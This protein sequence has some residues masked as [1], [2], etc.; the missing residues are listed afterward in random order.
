MDEMCLGPPC[1]HF[2]EWIKTLE[3]ARGYLA[4]TALS[5]PT[6]IHYAS[7]RSKIKVAPKA[8]R[9]DADGQVFA[10]KGEMVRYHELLLLERA[11]KI[12]NIKR[13]P[14][15]ELTI[16]GPQGSLKP[17]VIRSERYPEGR[18]CWYTADFQYDEAVP[19]GWVTVV[20]DFKGYQTEVS[21]LRIAVAE[22]I[23][24][25]QVRITKK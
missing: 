7:K 25:F 5:E 17:V 9:T 3:D 19:E 13:Q 1:T 24:G 23:Y 11:G 2:P 21:K 12:R 16:Q 6:M 8:E 18:Q 14:K 4:Y 15:F 20:E 22:A 10:S